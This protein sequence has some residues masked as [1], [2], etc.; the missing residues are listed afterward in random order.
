ME[1]TNNQFSHYLSHNGDFTMKLTKETLKRIIK[2]EFEALL[3]MPGD[4]RF[5]SKHDINPKD[6]SSPNLH[7]SDRR[8]APDFSTPDMQMKIEISKI[9]M[10]DAGLRISDGGLAAKE[11]VDNLQGKKFKPG[12]NLTDFLTSMPIPDKDIEDIKNKIMKEIN[13]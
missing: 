5:R 10:F 7:P 2:E 12:F 4:R 6:Y 8:E 9:L 13:Q 3:E 11:I 1:L